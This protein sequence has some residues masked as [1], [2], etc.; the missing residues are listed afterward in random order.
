[1]DD[2]PGWEK[3]YL[4]SGRE[5]F[6]LAPVLEAAQTLAVGAGA[7]P[8]GSLTLSTPLEQTSLVLMKEATR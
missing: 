7:R 4:V 6:R 1:L 8:P 3:F 2:A 5:A